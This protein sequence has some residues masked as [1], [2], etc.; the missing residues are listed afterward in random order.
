MD[1]ALLVPRYAARQRNDGTAL[2]SSHLRHHLD[3]LALFFQP[4]PDAGDEEV[5]SRAENQNLSG[6]DVRRDGMV[7]LL[8][9]RDRAGW[10][11]LF[12]DS[13]VRGRETCGRSFADWQVVWLVAAGVAPRVYI[14]LPART[15]RDGRR[16]SPLVPSRGPVYSRDCPAQ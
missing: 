16:Q 7:S 2:A 14:R 5:R 6:A 12:L 15:A 4:G 11:A 8:G 13:S 9:V 3:R 10:L 1:T